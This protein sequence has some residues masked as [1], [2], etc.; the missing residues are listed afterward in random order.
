RAESLEY[1]CDLTGRKAVLAALA[2]QPVCYPR[3][4]PRGYMQ[5]D[6]TL[7]KR[8]TAVLPERWRQAPLAPTPPGRL[9]PGPIEKEIT[10]FPC[11]ACWLIDTYGPLE[12]SLFLE[13]RQLFREYQQ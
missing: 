3:R 10:R 8:E 5:A 7:G 11:T 2:K 13:D 6:D 1:R 12:R 4:P 9:I